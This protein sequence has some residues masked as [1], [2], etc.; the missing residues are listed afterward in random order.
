MECLSCSCFAVRR[1]ARAITQQYDRDLKPT[2]L[3]ATQFTLLVVLALDGAKPLSQVAEALGTER[4]TLSRNLRRLVTR[5]LVRVGSHQD[6]RIQLLEITP[7][8]VAAARKALPHWRR[9]Q[10][11]IGG[12]F[13]PGALRSLERATQAASRT[14]SS[15]SNR[16]TGRTQE[17]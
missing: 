9:A 3:R 4:T 2:G 11:S 10:R 13:T 16:S 12:F 17:G 8:G 1:A 6:R 14:R 5:G 15:G 7:R